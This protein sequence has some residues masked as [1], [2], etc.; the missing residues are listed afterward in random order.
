MS[1]LHSQYRRALNGAVALGC[2]MVAATACTDDSAGLSEYTAALSQYAGTI[3]SAVSRKCLEAEDGIQISQ[4]SCHGELN[5]QF[6]VDPS[7]RDGT[8][9][10]RNLLTNKCVTLALPGG[11][12]G[13]D[14]VLGPCL[15]DAATWTLRSDYPMDQGG[16]VVGHQLVFQSAYAADHCMDVPG[17]SRDDGQPLQAFHECHSLDNQ[18]FEFRGQLPGSIRVSNSQLSITSGIF[19]GQEWIAPGTIAPL[20]AG[21]LSPVNPGTYQARLSL[22]FASGPAAGRVVCHED[23][24]IT[25]ADGRETE[26]RVPVLNVAHLLG[27]C[28]QSVVYRS[29]YLGTDF[30]AHVLELRLMFDG[31]FQYWA[32]GRLVQTGG[33]STIAWSPPSTFV[34]F[35]LDNTG[36]TD[37]T[38]GYPYSVFYTGR[39]GDT[40]RWDRVGAW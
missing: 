2:F 7:H 14:L 19:N 24:T 12:F 30:V 13:F 28:A 35:R 6:A 15:Q 18:V 29:S 38:I 34:T 8:F 32:D 9:Q 39:P 40:L 20:T 16:A 36:W 22:G 27:H 3:E 4:Y 10:I 37:S 25:V 1:T 26:F 11:P 17:W 21:V 31:T 33:V 23:Q 5:Q